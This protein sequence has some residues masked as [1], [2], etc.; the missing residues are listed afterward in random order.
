[1]QIENTAKTVVK[2]ES[3][4]LAKCQKI[5]DKFSLFTD[6]PVYICLRLSL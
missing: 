3:L 6:I 1:M 4:C 5:D 2:L